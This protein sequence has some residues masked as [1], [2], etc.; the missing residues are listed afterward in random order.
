[1]SGS[2]GQVVLSS[3]SVVSIDF[4]SAEE[5]EWLEET[6]ISGIS[7]FSSGGSGGSTFRDF[8]SELRWRMTRSAEDNGE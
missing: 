8:S 6:G 1:M 7:D 4:R 5:L 2:L 3:K